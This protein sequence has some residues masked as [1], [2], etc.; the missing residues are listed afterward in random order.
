MNMVTVDLKADAIAEVKRLTMARAVCRED[1]RSSLAPLAA[2]GPWITRARRSNSNLRRALGRNVLLLWRVAYEDAAGRLVDSRLVALLIALSTE[3][4]IV[5]DRGW[6]RALLQLV[7]PEARARVEASVAGW[8]DEVEAHAR[9][10]AS[11]RLSR[12][13][14]IASQA[15]TAHPAAF[16][17]GL[18]DRRA[19]H[20]R[21]L[22][23]ALIAD[24]ERERADRLAAVTARATATVRRPELVLVL[25][26]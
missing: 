13:R 19:E 4:P 16:Q 10:F 17:P 8:R 18:F 11:A 7:D 15:P 14:A 22:E 23:A 12:E 9:A 25:T 6:I 21:D 20:T 2:D 24:A 5:S 1:D 26:P 3:R